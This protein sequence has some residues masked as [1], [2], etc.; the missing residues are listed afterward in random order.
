[1]SNVHELI[2]GASGTSICKN[3][4]ETQMYIHTTALYTYR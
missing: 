3:S 4:T 2:K 1:M